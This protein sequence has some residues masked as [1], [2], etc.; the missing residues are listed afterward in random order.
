MIMKHKGQKPVHKSSV[1]F[2][3]SIW[4]DY[5]CFKVNWL[6]LCIFTKKKD[7][8]THKNDFVHTGKT[9]FQR[10][11]DIFLACPTSANK[12]NGRYFLLIF[13]TKFKLP[14]QTKEQPNN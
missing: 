4:M 14:H 3:L 6:V 1:R 5:K 8:H 10:R 2:I 13:K 7:T 9:I 12:E 11:K